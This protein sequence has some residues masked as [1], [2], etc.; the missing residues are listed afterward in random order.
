MLVSPAH[1]AGLTVSN[2]Q[3]QKI[4]PN[5]AVITWT[6]SEPT[7]SEV[8]YGPTTQY[9]LTVMS[10]QPVTH[11]SA[12]I[13]TLLQP[14]AIYH[15]IVKNNNQQGTVAISNDGYFTTV[16]TQL[17]VRVINNATHQPIAGATVSWNNYEDSTN[18]SGWAT[19]TDLPP[20]NTIIAVQ[21]QGTSLAQFI[22]IM[23]PGSRAQNINIPFVIPAG[24]GTNPWLAGF[25]LVV[26]FGL[27]LAVARQDAVAR[28]RAGWRQLR[29]PRL[30]SLRRSVRR[31]AGPNPE[32]QPHPDNVPA[33]Q[34][35]S[36]S[37]SELHDRFFGRD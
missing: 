22:Q 29:L 36:M 16:G 11:H 6:T 10:S 2:M 17:N 3:V 33:S 23:P 12:A 35:L 13:K 4:T 9:G 31:S 5:S 27:G 32:Q 25:A 26:A 24:G 20:G 30:P 28:L 21:Y 1:A 19:L 37:V 15:F 34:K 18:D 7:T 14:G 8:D